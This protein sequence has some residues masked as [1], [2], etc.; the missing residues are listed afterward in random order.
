M[1]NEARYERLRAE[2]RQLQG[3]MRKVLQHLGLEVPT[4]SQVEEDRPRRFVEGGR[5]H[6]SNANQ[7]G[8]GASMRNNQRPPRAGEPA[9]P[10]VPGRPRNKT[11]TGRD[12]TVMTVRQVSP[13]M[14]RVESPVEPAAAPVSEVVTPPA[15][16]PGA[17]E[18]QALIE[19]AAGVA[20]K[21]SNALASFG[22]QQQEQ[23]QHDDL[24]DGDPNENWMAA[25]GINPG[26][27]VQG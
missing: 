3:S 6:N 25:E 16:S 21:L 4:F 27:V 20:D 18:L 15:P 14:G 17:A 1:S 11:T 19:V 26:H 22:G 2:L 23:Q 13:G 7:F 9:R 8:G 24:G 5:P 12:G 10:A